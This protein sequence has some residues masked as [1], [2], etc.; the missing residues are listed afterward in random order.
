MEI[1]N[2][3]KNRKLAKKFAKPHRIVSYW[4]DLIDAEND[5]CQHHGD[6]KMSHNSE[7]NVTINFW[8][9][10]TKKDRL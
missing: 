10:C 3:K 6:G 9:Y 4:S 7:I 2:R 1:E 5:E 8:E